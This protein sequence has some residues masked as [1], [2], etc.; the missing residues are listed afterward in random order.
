MGFR[1]PYPDTPMTHLFFMDDLYARKSNIL[2]DTLMV[3]DR[4][5]R[6]IGMELGL[7]KCTV[8]HIKCGKHVSPWNRAS[9]SE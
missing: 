9:V 6:A 8:A 2:G 5:S 3:A 7:R 1:V 4:V